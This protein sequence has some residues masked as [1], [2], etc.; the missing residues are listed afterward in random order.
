MSTRTQEKRIWQ[1]TEKH[2]GQVYQIRNVPALSRVEAK[3][4]YTQKYRQDTY[5]Q[6]TAIVIGEMSEWEGETDG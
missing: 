1:V 5:T 4:I 6:L 2:R 3:A